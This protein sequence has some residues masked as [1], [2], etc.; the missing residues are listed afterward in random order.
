MKGFSQVRL[1]L[2]NDYAACIQHIKKMLHVFPLD[3]KSPRLLHHLAVTEACNGCNCQSNIMLLKQTYIRVV[4][5]VA[6]SS[7]CLKVCLC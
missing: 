7:L 3:F 2:I 1:H 5:T 6:V 4:E